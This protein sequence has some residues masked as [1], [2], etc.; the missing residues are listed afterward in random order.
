MSDETDQNIAF[1]TQTSQDI[2]DIKGRAWNFITILIL[3]TGGVLALINNSTA[4]LTIVLMFVVVL[5]AAIF[6]SFISK[7]SFDKLYN[8]RKRLEEVIEKMPCIKQLRDEAGGDD[9]TRYDDGDLL[10]LAIGFM[11]AP[12]LSVL[13]VL[14]LIFAHTVK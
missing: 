8:S 2:R 11:I 14:V 10:F 1:Y 6:T 9:I 4:V 3:I 7:Q 13:L 5:F 12:V